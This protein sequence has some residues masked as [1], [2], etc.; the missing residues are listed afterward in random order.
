[1]EQ[2]LNQL[3]NPEERALEVCSIVA[4]SAVANEN[5]G[6]TSL[7]KP[8]THSFEWSED[9]AVEQERSAEAVASL[10]NQLADQQWPVSTIAF[11]PDE[12][13]VSAQVG[14]QQVA[15]NVGR[16]AEGVIVITFMIG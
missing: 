12:C 2:T 13:S 14:S 7:K 9:L 16:N 4:C 6:V 3:A 8:I 5:V 1:M 10:I 11:D 15:A